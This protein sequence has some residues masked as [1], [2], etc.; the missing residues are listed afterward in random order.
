M[1]PGLTWD[2]A[3]IMVDMS[4]RS[5]SGA[6]LANKMTLYYAFIWFCLKF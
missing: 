4:A 2:P 1:S 5:D 6:H 3:M